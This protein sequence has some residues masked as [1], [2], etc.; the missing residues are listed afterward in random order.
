MSLTVYKLIARYGADRTVERLAK[1]GPA[2][3]VVVKTVKRRADEVALVGDVSQNNVQFYLSYADLE[4][5]G[6]PLPLR[7]GDRIKEADGSIYTLRVVE[8]MHTTTGDVGGYRA[9]A[10]GH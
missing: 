1:P 10:R 5:A 7:K 9:W 3:E 4:A 6:F 8:D 2:T